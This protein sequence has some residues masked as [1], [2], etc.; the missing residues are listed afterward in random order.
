MQVARHP[1]TVSQTDVEH[2]EVD[3]GG[4]VEHRADCRGGDDEAEL[5]MIVENR[6]QAS[7]HRFVVIHVRQTHTAEAGVHPRLSL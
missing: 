4:G 7:A 1:G 5:G 3:V 6:G 2:D